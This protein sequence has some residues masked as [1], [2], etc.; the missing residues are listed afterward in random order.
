MSFSDGTI[1][2]VSEATQSSSLTSVVAAEVI[3]YR[4]KRGWTVPELAQQVQ[5]R[6]VALSDIELSK[7]ESLQRPTI[8]LDELFALAAALGVAPMLLV[9]P[10]GRSQAMAPIDRVEVDPL[11]GLLWAMGERD[12]PGQPAGSE[13]EPATVGRFL[14]HERHVRAWLR[15]RDE[16]VWLRREAAAAIEERRADAE[17]PDIGPWI[18]RSGG[19]EAARKQAELAAGYERDMHRY[20]I[21]IE[22]IRAGLRRDGLTPPGLPPDLEH[23]D[24]EPAQPHTA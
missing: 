17:H 15:A 1:E 24:D 8:S 16:A 18:V 19:R 5:D 3:R 11:D 10:L 9:F 20:A 12:L 13:V 14:E 7:L 4:R 2:V 21:A 6:G 23:L 22:R